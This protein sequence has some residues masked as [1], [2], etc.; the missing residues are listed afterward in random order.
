MEKNKKNS[1]QE[2]KVGVI[3]VG[4]IQ[5]SGADLA[6]S[7]VEKNIYHK[8]VRVEV[9]VNDQVMGIEQR[10]QLKLFERS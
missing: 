10:E 2:E 5:G 4:Y 8:T 3:T 6:F 9:A 7:K 1:T